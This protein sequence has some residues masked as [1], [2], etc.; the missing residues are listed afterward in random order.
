MIGGVTPEEGKELLAKFKSGQASEEEILRAFQAAPVVEFDFAKV[1]THRSLR[2]GFPEVIFGAGKTAEQVVAIASAVLSQDQRVLIT[3][4][5]P[6]HVAALTQKFPKAVHH[7]AARIV[8]VQETP[9]EKRPG[10]ND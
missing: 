7:K 4:V 10:T 8:V 5:T 6:E 2:K 3:R 1:D 9:L